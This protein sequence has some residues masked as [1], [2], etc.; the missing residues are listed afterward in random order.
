MKCRAYPLLQTTPI[1]V[2]HSDHAVQSIKAISK[3]T[4]EKSLSL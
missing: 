3:A 1:F 4:M 2:C